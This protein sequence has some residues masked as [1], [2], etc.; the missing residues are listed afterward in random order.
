MR[1]GGCG[2]A[3]LLAGGRS[4]ELRLTTAAGDV[5]DALRSDCPIGSS[6]SSSRAPP[7]QP[8]LCRWPTRAWAR[9]V[10]RVRRGLV[11]DCQHGQQ[12][13]QQGVAAAATATT[14]AQLLVRRG[15]RGHAALAGGRSRSCARSLPARAHVTC[16]ISQ[17][18]RDIPYQQRRGTAAGLT[19]PVP[20]QWVI[21]FCSQCDVPTLVHRS[22]RLAFGWGRAPQI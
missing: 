3:A 14:A 7:P 6:S 2:H 1:R 8:P 19:N 15:G 18:R 16:Q 11:G 20:R 9:L 17:V 5:C 4:Q 22:L 13:Q 10:L 12:R 21:K